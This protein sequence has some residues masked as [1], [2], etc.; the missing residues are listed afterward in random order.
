MKKPILLIALMIGIYLHSKAQDMTEYKASNGIIYHVGDTI[1]L[2][3]GSGN[4][5]QFVYM[6]PSS[7]NDS[8]TERD[9]IKRK[10]TH[11]AVILKKI[12]SKN[13]NGITNHEF[14]VGIG[15]LY[16]LHM[17]IES[18]IETSE[19]LSPKTN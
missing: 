13:Q 12:K 18:A 4:A 5:G 15:A 3:R 14:V 16:N 8:N 17:D 7:L 10:F 9:W 6:V 11:G 19:V 2:G 1:K